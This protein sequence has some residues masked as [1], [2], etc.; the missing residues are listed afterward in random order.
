MVDD[1]ARVRR[2]L[3]DLIEASGGMQVVATAGDVSEALAA[4]EVTSPAVALVDVLLPARADGLDVVRE[5]TL[6][7]RRVIATSVS[8]SVRLDALAAGASRFVEKA[9]DDQRLLSVLR[10]SAECS[11]DE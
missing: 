8:A 10:H 3:H 4:D 7:G 5:L 9:P 2:A 1:D 6:R 11:L